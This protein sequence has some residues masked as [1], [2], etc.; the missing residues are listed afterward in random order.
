MQAYEIFRQS[1]FDLGKYGKRGLGF[2]NESNKIG[3]LM[4]WRK[5]TFGMSVRLLMI[6]ET[7]RGKHSVVRGYCLFSFLDRGALGICDG[8]RAAQYP[9]PKFNEVMMERKKNI[10]YAW[11]GCYD[12]WRVSLSI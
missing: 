5:G 3:T 1:V 6:S 9:P 7:R 8:A 10:P 4:M 12:D 2:N 11:M